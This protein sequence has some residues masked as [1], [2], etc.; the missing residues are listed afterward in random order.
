MASVSPLAKRL[1]R[2]LAH[3][4]GK[5]AALFLLISLTIAVISG[6]LVA[7]RSIERVLANDKA[8]CRLEDYSLCTQFE[9]SDEALAAAEDVGP[10]SRIYRSFYSDVALSATG[11]DAA[12]RQEGATKDVSATVRLFKNRDEIDTASYVDGSAPVADDQI[13]LS[14]TF[15]DNN[16]LRVGDTV[17]VS[18]RELTICGL[19][20]LPDYQALMVKNTDLIF[21]GL[22]FTVAQVT[23]QAFDRL[24]GSITYH[25]A[26]IFDERDLSLKERDDHERDVAKALS[27][28]GARVTELHDRTDNAGLTYADDDLVGDQTMYATAGVILLV[29]ASFAFAVLTD[30]TIEGEAPVIGTLL[31]S[32]YRKGELVRHYLALPM[33]VGVMAAAAGNLLG[34]GVLARPYAT[35]YYT[36]YD[37]PPY[38]T[39]FFPE[40]LATTTVLPLTILL[41]ITFAG[42][43]R[44]LGATPLA[45]LRGEVGHNSR[46]GGLPL[47][48]AW[49]FV[50]RFRA[51]VLLRNLSHFVVLFGGILFSSF[52]LVFGNMMLPTIRYSGEQAARAIPAGHLYLLKAP[53]EIDVSQEQQDGAAA[54]KELQDL[55]DP[56]RELSR[57]RYLDLMRRASLIADD[58]RVRA[59]HPLNSRHNAPKDVSE[60]EKFSVMTLR[61]PRAGSSGEEE[62]SVYGIRVNSSYWKFDVSGGKIVMGRGLASKCDVRPGSQ[63][64]FRDPYADRTYTLAPDVIAGSDTDM[65]VYMSQSTWAEA[66]ERDKDEFNGYASDESL[67]LDERYVAGE[68]TPA[69]A[70]KVGDQIV[71][72]MGNIGRMLTGLAVVVSLL[73]IYLLTKTVIDRSARHISYMKVFGYHESEIRRLYLRSITIA[74]VTSL[75]LTM[76]LAL[77]LAERLMRRALADYPGYLPFVVPPPVLALTLGM[78]LV[79]YAL[80]VLLHVLHIRRVP[81]SEAL[82]VQE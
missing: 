4:P 36:S 76:P 17:R 9:A 6:Y 26:G 34:Y 66:F 20:A 70:R 33:A 31:A 52:V 10:G 62:V 37:L 3:N 79:A 65:N 19:V 53:L 81:L 57:E 22:T 47:P 59:G 16:G 82:K 69:Q 46:R 29:V 25:Y 5:Y 67:S 41:V 63:Y 21:D 32:G 30:A 74:V 14:R 7:A 75:V 42:V 28:H 64:T 60:A 68:L 50:S 78:E 43:M 55:Q 8:S 77:W 35:L 13:A 27:D 73:L 72:S 61:V 80:V 58:P 54:L 38:Q 48:R 15:C 71:T 39:F 51:R 2:E 56:A 45:F 24:K 18:G 12:A 1:P 40:L 44:K 11:R 49:G 23:P